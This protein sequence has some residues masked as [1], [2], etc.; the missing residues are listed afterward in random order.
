MDLRHLL[1]HVHDLDKALADLDER[2]KG[3][4]A[5]GT[6]AEGAV[7]VHMDGRGD[8]RALRIDDELVA[9]GGAAAVAEAVLAALRQA[10]EIAR[11]HREEE[12]ARLTGGLRIPE[13]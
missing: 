2:L 12:R 11:A 9:A 7:E 5:V 10:T 4:E 8:V 1:Q 6:G 13:F 3:F